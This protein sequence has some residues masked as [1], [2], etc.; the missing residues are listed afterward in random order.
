MAQ[1]KQPRYCVK[2]AYFHT[3][4]GGT[5]FEI[6]HFTYSDGVV[7]FIT[8]ESRVNESEPVGD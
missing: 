5:I 6:W 2:E 8:K 4:K 7:E 1:L 3:V